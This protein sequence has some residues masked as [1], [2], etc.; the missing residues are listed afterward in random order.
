MQGRPGSSVWPGLLLAVLGTL[1]VA[2][3][4]LGM[5]ALA[6]STDFSY[7]IDL[8][9]RWL[10]SRLVWE[11]ID[12][13][14]AW[15]PES[16]RQADSSLRADKPGLDLGLLP[17]YPPWAYT[18]GLVLVPPL[19][20]P[21]LRW[22][23]VLLNA[24]AL[25][26][27]ARWAYRQLSGCGQTWGWVAV[28][29]ALAM[30]PMAV[31]I[32]YGQYAVIIAGCLAAADLLLERQTRLGDLVAGIALGIACVK[33]HL[34]GLFV[35]AV[36]IESRWLAVTS[37]AAYLLATSGLAWLLSGSDPLTMLA[38]SVKGAHIFINGSHNPLVPWV[39]WL[40]GFRGAT[41]ILGLAGLG[42][43]LVLLVRAR[44]HPRLVRWG[45][46]A[47]VAMLWTYRRHY[48]IPLTVFPL[49]GLLFAALDSRK[50]IAWIVFATFGL[51]VWIPVRLGQWQ[52]APV[53]W[54]ALAVWGAGVGWLVYE[55]RRWGARVTPAY[56]GQSVT[57]VAPDHSS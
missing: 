51:T 38:E 6:G 10:E 48:D 47:V 7:P 18:T 46:C 8:R 44:S 52:L 56:P 22:Y 42:I 35:L 4:A 17:G 36:L 21:L 57:N 53:Q 33:P 41:A 14:E 2:Y 20:W 43:G 1:S 13:Q 15:G 45:I 11:G 25:G 30:F 29:S 26:I 34:A 39:Q 9:L 16:S 27:I 40:F 24:A 19:P 3:T 54:A 31:C 12:P 49:I 32:S 23:S 37:W 5:T 50:A 55:M 28:A